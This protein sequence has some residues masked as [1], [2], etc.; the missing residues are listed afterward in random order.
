MLAGDPLEHG[1]NLRIIRMV[2]PDGDSLPA[3]GCDLLG[4]FVNGARST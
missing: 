4:R 2:T 3:P 1:I